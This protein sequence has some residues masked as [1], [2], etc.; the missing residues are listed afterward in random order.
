MKVHITKGSNLK[1]EKISLFKKRSFTEYWVHMNLELTQEEYDIAIK[2]EISSISFLK[3][4]ADVELK[5]KFGQSLETQKRIYAA[6][7]VSKITKYVSGG[8]LIS[9]QGYTFSHESP[10]KVSNMEVSLRDAAK[11]VKN[12]IEVIRRSTK[13]GEDVYEL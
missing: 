10:V 9:N 1:T 7:G 4:D 2:P 11:D 13:G 5:P 8:E 12:Y 3:Y 6:A